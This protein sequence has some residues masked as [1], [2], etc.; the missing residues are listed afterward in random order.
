[1]HLLLRAGQLAPA[2]V[3]HELGAVRE[4]LQRPGAHLAR[5]RNR[6]PRRPVDG[7]GLLLHH[8]EAAAA[9][10]AIEVVVE[11]GDVGMAAAGP[12][13]ALGRRDERGRIGV[14]Q[15]VAVPG[16]DVQVATHR[17]VVELTEEAHE[18]VQHGAA[19]RVGAQHVGL[20]PVEAQHFVGSE[21]APIERVDRVGLRGHAHG[22]AD[23]LEAVAGHAP[24]HVA[25]AFVE[26]GDVA[27]A[28]LQPVAEARQRLRRVRLH[29][30]VA[31][32]LVVGL[33]A[34]HGRVLAVAPR[35][36]LDDGQRGRHV[37]VA[38]KANMSTRTGAAWAPLRV[39]RQ[40][41]RVT[42]G[43]PAR[44]RRRR[45][46]QHHLQ[47]GL[48]QRVHRLVEPCPLELALPRLHPCPRKFGD[49]HQ[50]QAHGGHAPSVVPPARRVP[51][52]GVI[53]DTKFHGNGNEK[54][55]D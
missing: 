4:R 54:L 13:Q 50:L 27:V 29:R 15:R 46:S 52:F 43:E 34:H 42:F 8:A 47:P 45:R 22:Q 23:L 26:R 44:R 3:R 6:V 39:H 5:L 20:Q 7:A 38:G 9:H 31:A 35:H 12:A 21:A 30:V 11:G 48:G 16:G 51:L 1:M 40:Y 10:V 24:E 17:V 18:V 41:F 28:Q 53:A 32:V 2:E 36:R 55:S 49:P 25:P 37:F 33:P 14:A 19:R